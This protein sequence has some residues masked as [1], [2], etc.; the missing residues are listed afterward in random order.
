MFMSKKK[1]KAFEE[2]LYQAEEESA[3]L[4]RKVFSL[5]EKLAKHELYTAK[6][7]SEV[8]KKLVEVQKEISKKITDD[9][10]KQNILTMIKELKE[11]LDFS[12]EKI[13]GDMLALR[14]AR[15]EEDEDGA[16][17]MDEYLNGG[18]ADE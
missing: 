5:E 8:Y 12:V 16:S 3:K 10:E 4:K 18:K 7:L 17:I 15:G 1:I 11:K 6:E 2:R 13:Y 14:G 9:C